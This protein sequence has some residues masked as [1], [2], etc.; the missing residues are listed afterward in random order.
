M[1][2]TR[3]ERA[4]LVVVSYI[5]GAITVFIGLMSQVAL[6]P[7]MVDVGTPQTASLIQ[8]VES[9]AQPSA[10]IVN[11]REGLLEVILPTGVRTL[12]YNPE[13]TGYAVDEEFTF[14]GMHYDTPVYQVSSNND[15][16]FFCEKKTPE[17]NLCQPF[18]Y[19]ILSDTI[20]PVKRLA[21]T[22][23]IQVTEA[24]NARFVDGILDFGTMKSN[25][26]ANPW[27]LNF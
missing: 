26:K 1:E 14:Q 24:Q 2:G 23:Q 15:H 8:A 5:I 27:V 3:N 20:Y 11:Y 25:S 16:V 17:S 10:G 21:G 18:V 9:K 6:S 7:T 12:S 13:I 4:A 19:D 22:V